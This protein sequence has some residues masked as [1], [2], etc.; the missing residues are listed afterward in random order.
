MKP[1]KLSTLE[2]A[3]GISLAVHAVL[4]TVRFVDP[5]AIERA[6]RDTPLEVIL[7][8]ARSQSA[9][10]KAQAIAQSDQPFGAKAMR[11]G[12]HTGGG[13]A[14]RN[15]AMRQA[16]YHAIPAG[17][18]AMPPDHAG[19]PPRLGCGIRYGRRLWPWAGPVALTN[20]PSC[21]PE[22]RVSGAAII[23]RMT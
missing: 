18:C 17:L 3:L 15:M 20:P 10:E 6:F 16:Q 13:V 4:L 19:L 11:Q 12:R 7:V 9:A 2:L 22:C 21:A 14:Y 5:E 8:N 23:P 1:R